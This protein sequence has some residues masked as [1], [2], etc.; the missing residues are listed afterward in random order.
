M[1]G[2]EASVFLGIVVCRY[3]FVGVLHCSVYDRWSAARYQ[4]ISS[5]MKMRIE[6]HEV[7]Y[8]TLAKFGLTR[9]MIEDL[10][11]HV[12]EDIGQGRRSPVL[13][14]QVEDEN[15]NIIKSRTRFAFVRME[16]GTVDVVFYPVLNQAPLKQYDQEQQKQLLAGKAILADMMMDGKQS[17]AFV[18]LDAETNQV[19]YAPTPV[20]GRNLQVLAG[21]MH[22]SL[23]EVN[24]IQNG[25]PLTFVM[26]EEPVTVG[27]DLNDS[28]GIRLC[29]GDGQKWKEQTKREWD[30]YTFGCYGCWVMDDD[31]NLDYVSEDDYTEELW[32]ELSRKREG[33]Q[34]RMGHH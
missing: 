22:L 32:N 6:E 30:K 15:E 1:C 4:Q 27:I 29:Q 5:N 26:E 18:Q 8:E 28:T 14:I 24:V 12:L 3:N 13:P 25:E 31:G 2:Y 16:D 34:T 10:P 9:E 17:K 7:P 21:E 19:I 33:H 11:M 23:A 20:I